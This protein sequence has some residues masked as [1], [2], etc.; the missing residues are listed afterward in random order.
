MRISIKIASDLVT[1]SLFF[2]RSRNSM[3]VVLAEI[4]REER[5]TRAWLG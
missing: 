5:I 3:I 2:L 1:I 4:T